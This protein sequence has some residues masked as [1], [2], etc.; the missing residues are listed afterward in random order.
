MKARATRSAEPGS[1]ARARTAGLLLS[2]RVAWSVLLLGLACSSRA[3]DPAR[4]SV[5]V[6]A[7][8][9][10]PAERIA[11]LEAVIEQDRHALAELV[12]RPR[13]SKAADFEHDEALRTLAGRLRVAS[14]ELDRLRGIAR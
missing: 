9:G 6:L 13:D 4:P 10:T 7:G 8:T 5:E 2:T 14:R 1:I 3:T 11:T 12:S